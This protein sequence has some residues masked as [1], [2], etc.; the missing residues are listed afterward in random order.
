MSGTRVKPHSV[1]QENNVDLSDIKAVEIRTIKD[2][3]VTRSGMYGSYQNE[4][5]VEGAFNNK[6]TDEPATN[7][8]GRKY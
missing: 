2:A 7:L 4:E 3:S 8:L 5:V 6:A 1:S